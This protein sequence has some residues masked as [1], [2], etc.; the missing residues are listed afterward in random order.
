MALNYAAEEERSLERF[1]SFLF[2]SRLTFCKAAAAAAAVAAVISFRP[3]VS[4]VSHRSIYTLWRLL[5][6][7]SLLFAC[8]CTY[9][10]ANCFHA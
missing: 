8:V 2:S 5:K 7:R 10:G 1:I 4:L 6:R 9:N 3:I